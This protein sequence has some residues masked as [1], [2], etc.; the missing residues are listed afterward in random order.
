MNNHILI[1]S[2]HLRPMRME[3]FDSLIEG[4]LRVSKNYRKQAKIYVVF[5]RF[6]LL[7]QNELP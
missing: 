5:H 1:D 2:L 7:S 6:P 4:N 3:H